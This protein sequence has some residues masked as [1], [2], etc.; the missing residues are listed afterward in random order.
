[1]KNHLYSDKGERIFHTASLVAIVLLVALV[2]FEF[3]RI[4]SI[5]KLTKDCAVTA[6]D[7][8]FIR[9]YPN[10]FCYPDDKLK[11]LS[12]ELEIPY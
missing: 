4:C 10:K 2:C 6:P 7:T 12:L 3:G 9:A 11:E 8:A 5:E 1:M